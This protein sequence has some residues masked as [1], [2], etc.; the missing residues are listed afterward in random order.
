VTMVSPCARRSISAAPWG[1][2][3]RRFEVG[4]AKVKGRRSR[5]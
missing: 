4:S 1:A 2:P 3:T 5:Q